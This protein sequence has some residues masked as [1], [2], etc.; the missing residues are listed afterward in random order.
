MNKVTHA[1]V[2][3]NV[4]DLVLFDDA[5]R[6]LVRISRIL[7]TPGRH[8]LLIGGEPGLGKRSLAQLA[9][10]IAGCHTCNLSLSRYVVVFISFCLTEIDLRDFL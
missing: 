1:N 4:S 10:F 3:E 8:A 7:H 5:I 9:S 2:P 6:Q